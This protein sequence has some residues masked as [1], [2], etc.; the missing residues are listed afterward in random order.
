MC[1]VRRGSNSRVSFVCLRGFFF[2]FSRHKLD[3]HIGLEDAIGLEGREHD[4]VQPEADENAG[5]DCLHGLGA[6]ELAADG[7]VS[8]EQKDQD[9]DQSLRNEQGHRETQAARNGIWYT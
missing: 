3:L 1:V 4:V 6:T 8:A 7:G 5:G 9:R 2:L